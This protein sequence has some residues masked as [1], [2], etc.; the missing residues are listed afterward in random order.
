MQIGL[1]TLS[2]VTK[3]YK[4]LLIQD[5]QSYKI[6]LEK[7]NY[8]I[9]CNNDNLEKLLEVDRFDLPFGSYV[10]TNCGLI[11]TSPRMTQD[12]LPYY[13]EKYYHPLN[14]GKE[15]LDNQVALFKSGQGKKIFN[16]LYPYVKDK[17]HLDILEIGAGV[18]NVLDEFRQKSI[19]KLMDI[20]LYGTEYSHD[21]IRQCQKRN[22][23]MIEGNASSVLKLNKKFDI[24]IL[25]HVFEHFIDLEDELNTLVKLLNNDGLLYIEVPGIL[26]NHNKPY[27]NF[28]FLG[29]AV[30]AHMYNFSLI[31]LTNILGKNS[32]S[33]LEGNEE[34]E[35]VFQIKNIRNNLVSND[36]HRIQHY[37]KFLEDN[38]MYAMKQ[39]EIIEKQK[40]RIE[41]RDKEIEKQ[42]ERIETRD[43]EIEKQKERIETR[44]KEIEKQKERI[45]T[46]DK[47]IFEKDNFIKSLKEMASNVNN[48]RLSLRLIKKYKMCINIVKVI[49]ETIH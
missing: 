16:T 4:E 36:Y 2:D 10:C 21:C 3:K 47:E 39:K 7:V 22:L 5:I 15:N 8:C 26:K 43:K 19:E 48:S 17:K 23:N 44:D 38:Q 20:E 45:E 29:Y 30:H 14:Y 34:V 28:S 42:K 32:F 40:E 24:I 12:S 25:S 46:R 33:L 41:T 18:G 49:H 9:C 35:A 31:T 27:Y 1:R 6:K 11:M 13:Y 37:L